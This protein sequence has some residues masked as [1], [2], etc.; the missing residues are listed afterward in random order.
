MSGGDK[1]APKRSAV[2]GEHGLLDEPE[3]TV[4][5]A[6]VILDELIQRSVKQLLRTFAADGSKHL[7]SLD[8]LCI[9]PC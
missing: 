3:R 1:G 2:I 7:R 9:Q 4:Q 5:L 8:I 6:A